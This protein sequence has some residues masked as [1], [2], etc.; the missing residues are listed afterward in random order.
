[1]CFGDLPEVPFGEEGAGDGLRVL[2]RTRAARFEVYLGDVL[3]LGRPLDV[4]LVREQGFVPVLITFGFSGLSVQLGDEWLVYE[5]ILSP[6]A[7]QSFWRFGI[8]VRTGAEM[9]DEHRIDNLL[10]V[11]GSE[12]KPRPV[13]VEVSSNGQQF[14]TSAVELMYEAPPTVSAFFPERGPQ[15]GSTVV[16]ILGDNL[17]AGTHYMCRFDGVAVDASFDESNST[18]HCAS[19]PRGTARSAALEV[20]LNSQQYTATGVN[21]TWYAP[22]TVRLITPTSGPVTGNTTVRLYGE[23]LDAGLDYYRC[24]FGASVV[25][26]SVHIEGGQPTLLCVSPA[27]LAERV[28]LE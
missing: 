27:H 9:Y 25:P 21:F 8:G 20:S 17:G 7:P 2:L 19:V 3:M 4:S 16:R 22:P 23:N 18:M 5:L 28:A 14:S 26:A 1:M 15:T 10:L 24:R 13:T 12:H 6:W 11:A